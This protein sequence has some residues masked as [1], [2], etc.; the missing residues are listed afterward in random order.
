MAAVL[1]KHL[2]ESFSSD[3]LFQHLWHEKTDLSRLS[4]VDLLRRDYKELEFSAGRI[5]FSSMPNP[6]A[7]VLER[8]DFIAD[9]RKY[10]ADHQLQFLLFNTAF[11]LPDGALQRELMVYRGGAQQGLM[12]KLLHHLEKSD[13][14]LAPHPKSPADP[15]MRVYVQ[16]NLSASRKQL[17]PIVS[18]FF[19]SL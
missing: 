3:D 5:G 13:L 4:S 7:S 12:D 8:A 10:I 2:P 18:A 19:S 14:N 11:S 6:L 9:M 1:K 15:H 17:V 16:R